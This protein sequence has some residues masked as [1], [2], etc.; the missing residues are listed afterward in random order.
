MQTTDTETYYKVSNFVC[1]E[2]YTCISDLAEFLFDWDGDKYASF[3]EWE[4]LYES[5]CP[6]CGEVINPTDN[7]AIKC[8]YCDCAIDADNFDIY[9]KEIC[10]YWLVSPYLGEKLRE[11]GEATFKRHGAWFWGRTCS[12]Q[13]I[14]LDEVIINIAL[15]G[16]NTYDN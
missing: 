4:N 6:Q 1:Q 2:V 16:G 11:C 8:P 7:E 14:A 9:P 12:G 3:D 5:C 10:E 13:A 15:N